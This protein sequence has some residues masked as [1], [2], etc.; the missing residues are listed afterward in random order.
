[1]K[2][3]RP[4]M[5]RVML[6][7]SFIHALLAT[8]SRQHADAAAMYRTLVD[9]YQMRLDQLYAL[10]CVLGDL[11]GPWFELHRLPVAQ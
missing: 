4:K 11:P 3:R 7:E 10:S 1:M 2:P 5:R 9:R 6:D 8:D